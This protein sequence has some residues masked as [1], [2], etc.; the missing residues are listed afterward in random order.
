MSRSAASGFLAAT[1]LWGVVTCGDVVGPDAGRS[2]VVAAD[3]DSTSTL[4]PTG[5]DAFPVPLID[6][7]GLYGGGQ[8][9]P[10]AF[11][12]AAAPVVSGPVLVAAIGMSNT[13]Q[14]WRALQAQYTGNATL[15]PTACA[16][17]TV[18]EWDDYAD[19]GWA[20]AEAYLD[21]K[22][23]DPDSIRVVWLK[24]TKTKTIAPTA[25]D[26]DHI[27]AVMRVRWP[28][29]A[30]VFVSGRIYGGYRADGEPAAY[31]SGLAVREFVLRHLGETAPWIAWGPYLWANGDTPRSDGLAWLPEDLVEDGIHPSPSGEAKVA[32]MLDAF[33]S[34]HPATEWYR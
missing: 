7:G 6:G 2:M 4:P 30:Q 29:V 20:R 11:H 32:A 21:R 33:F 3:C 34:S 5:T 10:P 28:N 23:L 31:E 26:L 19:S 15:L 8:N 22:G 24:V 25:D 1:L 17:C 27:L 13:I 16:G 9:A 12:L 14:E 18:D